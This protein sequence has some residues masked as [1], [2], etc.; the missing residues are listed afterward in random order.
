MFFTTIPITSDKSVELSDINNKMLYIPEG[1][2][3]GFQALTNNAEIIYFN[4]QFYHPESESGVNIADP[5]VGIQFPLDI[6]NQSDKDK[7]IGFLE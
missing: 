5:K 6:N 1:F 4:T 3:H 7:S 2:A